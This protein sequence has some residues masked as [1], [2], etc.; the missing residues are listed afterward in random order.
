[1]RVYESA[2]INEY[3]EEVFPEP[4]LMPRSPELRATA[5]LWID[6]CN[7]RFIPPFYKLL[8]EQNEKAQRKWKEKLTDELLFAEREG[9]GVFAGDY[10]PG[11]QCSLVDIAWYPFFERFDVLKHYR[12]MDIPTECRRLKAWFATMRQRAS[13]KATGHSTDY[14]IER[15]ARYADGSADGVTT[16]EMS[17][18]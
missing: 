17:G 7:T 14:Y 16:R 13:A 1:M 15:Y 9:L 18:T 10:W 5:R 8:L 3:L 4:A 2:I 12:G 11:K 6:F